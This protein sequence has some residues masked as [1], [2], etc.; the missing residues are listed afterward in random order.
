[1]GLSDAIAVSAGQHHGCALR[2]SGSVVCWGTND[3][4][5]LG[6]GTVAM[7]R[8]TPTPVVGLSDAVQISAGA[9]H[10]CA[11][12][13]S[14]SVVC[15]GANHLGQLGDGSTWNRP[16]PVEVVGLHDVI[17][18]S[19]GG[20]HTCVRTA[21]GTVACWGLRAY[22]VLGEGVVEARPC[23][24]GYPGACSL[25]PVTIV[26]VADAVQL[27]SG[28]LHTCA[29]RSGGAVLCWGRNAD[30]ALGDGLA[31]HPGCSDP[32]MIDCSQAPVPVRGLGDA[33]GIAAGTRHTCAIRSTGGIVCWGLNRSGQLG[34]GSQASTSPPAAVQGAS[35]AI[36]MAAGSYH[37]CSLQASGQV[38]CWG[39]NSAGQLGDGRQDHQR[40]GHADHA[41]VETADCSL[42]P[43]TVP[44]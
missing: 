17:E 42:V 12:R 28:Y 38:V 24:D 14:G 36:G 41:G 33:T 1:V 8:S 19:A 32:S 5:Q 35:G 10:T 44:L 39:D 26:G 16:S 29:R 6:D 9:W 43:V 30:G 18:I 15:W 7:Q 40:C 31:Q 11:L 34:T 25:T 22:G 4:C 20:V 37:S 3:S 13:T 2:S 23:R 21:A 27:S